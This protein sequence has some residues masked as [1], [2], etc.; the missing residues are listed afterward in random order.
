VSDAF[1]TANGLAKL[2]YIRDTRRSVGYRGFTLKYQPKEGLFY[3]YRWP[4]A[5]AIGAYE[6]DIHQGGNDG[7]ADYALPKYIS[8]ALGGK[9]AR[10]WPFSIPFRALTSQNRRNLLVAGKTM[11]Q[12][13]LVNS[14]TRLHPIEWSTGVGA[15]VSAAYLAVNAK[16]SDFGGKPEVHV[17]ARSAEAVYRTDRVKPETEPEAPDCPSLYADND[18]HIGTIQHAID[19]VL[20]RA[21]VDKRLAPLCFEG[22]EEARQD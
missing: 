18:G 1:G 11:A 8:N 16:G 2:P 6:A 5:I 20:K 4:D 12:S 22:L 19:P 13:F 3:G 9:W 7:G 10:P 15:G 21:K 14:A 17:V